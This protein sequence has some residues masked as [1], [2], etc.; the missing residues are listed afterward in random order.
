MNRQEFLA[1]GGLD[2]SVSKQKM[3]K[4][5]SNLRDYDETQFF[6]TVRNDTKVSLGCVTDRYVV[7]QNDELLDIILDKIGDE[8]YDLSQSKCGQFKGGKKI[9][10]FVKIDKKMDFGQEM[11]DTYV[12]AVSSHD[13]SARLAFGVTAKLHSCDNMFGL[14]MADKENQHIIKHTKR[15]EGITEHNKLDELI[16]QNTSG[17]SK[18][19]KTLSSASPSYEFIQETLNLVGR[20]DGKRVLQETRDKRIRLFTSITQEMGRKGN[21]YYGLF[22]GVTHYLTHKVKE[23]DT[24]EWFDFNLNGKGSDVVSKALKLSVAQMRKDGLWLN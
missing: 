17:I 18:V 20:V 6:A 8:R 13:G 9:F 7:K 24:D 1:D 21:S 15:M 14:L 2:F 10:F 12:Y 23:I 22:N 4:E 19:M 11:A 3:Y 5:S 16:Q